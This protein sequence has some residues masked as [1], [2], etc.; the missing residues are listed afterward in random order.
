MKKITEIRDSLLQGFTE[1]TECVADDGYRYIVKHAKA[2]PLALVHEWIVGQIGVGLG[3]PI[4]P[5][6]LLTWDRAVAQ[7][8]AHPDS[9]SLAQHP[10]FGSR[11][12]EDATI[13]QPSDISLVST[14][15]QARVLLFD[16]WVMNNDRS[17]GNPNL[18]WLPHKHEI[19]VIDHNLAL[20]SSDLD[21]F[22]QNHI[23]R[24]ARQYWTKEFRDNATIQMNSQLEKLS[25]Y[26]DQL[27]AEWLE[28]GEGT[29]PT[30]DQV[31]R[32]L[33]RFKDH[34]GQF[35]NQV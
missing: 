29:V 8:S 30:L 12:V 28:I 21:T 23:F 13:L 6:E 15:M 14:Q 24:D 20:D 31:D 7:Y 1:P 25:D 9:N 33:S 26:W 34:T 11:L 5:F 10:S 17:D 27:P 35:W 19:Y 32:M 4:P 16:W 22:W 2:R 3:L 18:L